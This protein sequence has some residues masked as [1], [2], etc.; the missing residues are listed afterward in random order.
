MKTS[1]NPQEHPFF[2]DN[3]RFQKAL[4]PS[5][6]TRFAH[7]N[8]FSTEI[9]HICV[10]FCSVRYHVLVEEGLL[11]IIRL[12]EVPKAILPVRK[13]EFF[14]LIHL[15]ERIWIREDGFFL[16]IHLPDHISAREDGFPR[17]FHLFGHI[18]APGDGFTGLIHLSTSPLKEHKTPRTATLT[19]RYTGC[20][21][22]LFF[23]VYSAEVCPSVSVTVADCSVPSR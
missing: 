17:F 3:F 16:L 23:S 6:F 5:P 22:F 1:N 11:G 12:S 15:S 7:K 19:R 8:F 14:C 9:I 21:A 20:S 18:S 4:F 2:V 13:D 10:D